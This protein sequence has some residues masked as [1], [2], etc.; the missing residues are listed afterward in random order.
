MLLALSDYVTIADLSV[1]ENT[2][3]IE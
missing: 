3:A 2:F 1:V